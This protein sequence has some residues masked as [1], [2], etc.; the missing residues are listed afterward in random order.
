[1]TSTADGRI[2]RFA[3]VTSSLEIRPVNRRF[4]NMIDVMGQG[5]AFQHD[6]NPVRD[7]PRGA[8]CLNL[9]MANV[10]ADYAI[11]ITAVDCDANLTAVFFFSLSLSLSLLLLLLL[12]LTVFLVRAERSHVKHGPVR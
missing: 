1:M 3:S 5:L 9:V 10:A 4:I 6:H 12:L 8:V 11:V 2:G 7:L